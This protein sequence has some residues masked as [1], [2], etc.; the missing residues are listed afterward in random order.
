MATKKL[1]V[2]IQPRQ[3]AET[4]FR[5]GMRFTRD[6]AGVEVDDATAKRVEAEQML[7]VSSARPVDMEGDGSGALAAAPEDPAARLESIRAA[8]VALDK[9]DASLWTSGGKPKTEA[10]AAVTGWPV[11]AAERDAA[12]AGSE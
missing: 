10:L 9:E 4:F 8:I 2:R 12:L 7:E 11:T 5:C 1:W 6:W 3:K